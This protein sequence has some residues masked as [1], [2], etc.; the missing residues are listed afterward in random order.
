MVKNFFLTSLGTSI[1]LL[2]AEIPPHQNLLCWRKIKQHAFCVV[3]RG[4]FK[5]TYKN[6]N[7]KNKTAVILAIRKILVTIPFSWKK[8]CNSSRFPEVFWISRKEGGK[9]LGLLGL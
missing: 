4:L 8:I 7:N 3:D 9:L 2:L 6:N 1:T 5:R